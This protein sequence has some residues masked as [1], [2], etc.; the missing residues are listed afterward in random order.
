MAVSGF[1]LFEFCFYFLFLILQARLM[2][3]YKI[4]IFKTGDYFS[5][6]HYSCLYNNNNY[7]AAK[8]KS[9]SLL[10]YNRKWHC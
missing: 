3:M 8:W 4:M 2:K 7:A 1:A 5:V 10:F 9:S 6:E